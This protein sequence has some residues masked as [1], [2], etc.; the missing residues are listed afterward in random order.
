VVSGLL[1]ASAALPAEERS[2]GTSWIG[3]RVGPKA[4]LGGNGVRY[5]IIIN[6]NHSV[7]CKSCDYCMNWS[8]ELRVIYGAATEEPRHVYHFLPRVIWS[9]GGGFMVRQTPAS[10]QAPGNISCCCMLGPASSQVERG[11]GRKQNASV[12]MDL[13][14]T[15]PVV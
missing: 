5:I 11:K 9:R 14:L 4:G 2:L 12:H 3:G 6:I 7:A 10:D 15:A 8:R 13:I 1:Q